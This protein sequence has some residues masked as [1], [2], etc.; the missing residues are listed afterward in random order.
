MK[1]LSGMVIETKCY[2]GRTDMA[3]TNLS[4]VL[5]QKKLWY[6]NCMTLYKC[7]TNISF[8]SI[9]F[10]IRTKELSEE[11]IARTLCL[12]SVLV[13]CAQANFDIQTA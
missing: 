7:K 8:I 9:N 5:G 3:K 12:K 4:L 2:H 13:N 6:L 11:Y 1:S 10:N